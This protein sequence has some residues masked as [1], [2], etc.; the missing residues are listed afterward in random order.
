MYERTLQDEKWHIVFLH[1]FGKRAGNIRLF[2][3]FCLY[4]GD[5]SF[6]ILTVDPFSL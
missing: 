5:L 2:L 3:I 4:F 6:P 1:L